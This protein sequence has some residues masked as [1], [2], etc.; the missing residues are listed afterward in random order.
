MDF[1]ELHKLFKK[2]NGTDIELDNK[3][4][5]DKYSIQIYSSGD[6]GNF[7]INNSPKLHI[8]FLDDIDDMVEIL[9]CIKSNGIDGVFDYKR[10]AHY[11][12]TRNIKVLETDE[13]ISNDFLIALIYSARK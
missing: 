6:E 7:I 9:P 8:R 2:H 5:N 4:N 1:E 10:R 12:I 3:L 11:F 13:L